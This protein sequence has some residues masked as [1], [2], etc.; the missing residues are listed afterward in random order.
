MVL[1]LPLDLYYWFVTVFA[2]NLTIFMALAFLALTGL[3]AL[4]RLPNEALFISF[5]LFVLM[6]S[7]YLEALAILVLLIAGLGIGWIIA[8][9]WTR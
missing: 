1:H 4:F 9:I 2:G 5:A 3:S 8:K 6:L 7:I